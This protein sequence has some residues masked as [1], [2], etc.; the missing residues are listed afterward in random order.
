[1]LA[2]IYLIQPYSIRAWEWQYKLAKVTT[3]VF[4]TVYKL[5]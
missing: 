4:N 5:P 2:V 1:M 3:Y